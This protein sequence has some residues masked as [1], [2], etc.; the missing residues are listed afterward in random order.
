MQNR[1]RK[2]YK[3]TDFQK[4]KLLWENLLGTLE[5]MKRKN[6]V[7]NAE[8][9]LVD[10]VKMESPTFPDDSHENI[11]CFNSFKILIT[12]IIDQCQ[13]RDL[14]NLTLSLQGFVFKFANQR[15]YNESRMKE[16]FTA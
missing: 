15:F 4:M 11:K 3:Q 7:K 5:S 1:K 16:L 14:T 9:K 13:Q 10:L 2:S 6:I 8:K 12:K